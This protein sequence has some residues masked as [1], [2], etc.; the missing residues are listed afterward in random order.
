MSRAPLG[1]AMVAA[2]SATLAGCAVG[3]DYVRPS[4]D[5]PPAYKE[6]G[7]WKPAAP[8][9]DA[10]RG[11][12][13]EIF[14]DPQLNALVEQVDI[15]NANIAAAEAQFRAA[16]AVVA[17]ARANYF[18][19][20]NAPASVTRSRSPSLPNQVVTA[21]GP[22]ENYSVALSASWE[23][24]LWGQVRRQVEANV[25][26]AQASAATLASARLSAQAT[27][28]QDYLLLRVVDGQKQ[29]LDDTVAAYQR[30]LELTQN[31]YA[32]GVA[33]KADVVQ[34]ETQVKSAQAQ[35]IDIGVQ[36]AQ[37][38]HAIAVLIGKPPSEFS[39]PPAPLV[40]VLP[41]IPAGVPSALLE[42]RPDV[43]TA[44][45]A[46]AA[47][48]AQIGVA[49]AAYYPA[50]TLSAADGY[51]SSSFASWLTAPSRFWSLGGSLAQVVFDGG[52]RRAQTAQARAA[53]D[54]DVATYRETVL[55]GFQEVEDNLAA[56]RILAL[57]A[58]IQ[59]GAVKSAR[60]SVVLTLNQYKAGIV[61]YLNVVAVQTV[62]FNN[63]STAMGILG[64]RFNAAVLLVKA[65]GGGWDASEIPTAGAL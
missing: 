49:I 3:P 64:R 46:M 39:I 22:V 47:A 37:L 10:S 35:A 45:R 19:T 28:A 44:E 2:A 9:D 61:S 33:A 26:T 60:E 42:R 11:Q 27:L 58:E 36:R 8:R 14:G 16:R 17:E 15:S 54:A 25:A 62:A 29:L 5:T 12:W 48:N 13:W 24:D 32:A 41:E 7:D 51:R 43:A 1:L 50:L 31:R 34:A 53:Y 57:E 40:A 30:T 6:A 4:V 18:P 38:E 52:L 20:V 63:E 23:P 59:D 55:N 56:L 21:P 65:L